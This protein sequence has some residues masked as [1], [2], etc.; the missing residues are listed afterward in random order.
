MLGGL[1]P[2]I[3][4]EL[5]KEVK[6]KELYTR[7]E[8]LISIENLEE[9]ILAFSATPEGE[10]TTIYITKILEPLNTKISRLGRGLSTG[11]EIE[12]ADSDTLKNALE[13]RRV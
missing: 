7:A 11:T 6:A 13:R 5:P 12:Y 1:I 3:G 9:I 2:G 8:K 4:A 10:N